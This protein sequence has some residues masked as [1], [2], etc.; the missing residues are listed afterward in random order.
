[1]PIDL[2]A[3]RDKKTMPPVNWTIIRNVRNRLLTES[4][5]TQ[6]SDNDLTAEQRQAW[7]VYREKLRRVP[8]DFPTPQSVVWPQKP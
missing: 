4:D 6:V 2:D 7:R 5:W 8:E 3:L 1:M